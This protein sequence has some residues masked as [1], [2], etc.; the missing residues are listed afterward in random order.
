[1]EINA[2][3][4]GSLESSLGGDQRWQF[5]QIAKYSV[6]PPTERLFRPVSRTRHSRG[7]SETNGTA[8]TR[9]DHFHQRIV[10]HNSNSTHGYTKFLGYQSQGV[11]RG[12]TSQDHRRVRQFPNSSRDGM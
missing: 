5:P 2:V 1:M 11:K 9:H 6:G 7:Y 3:H 10:T 8:T 12:F 4:E